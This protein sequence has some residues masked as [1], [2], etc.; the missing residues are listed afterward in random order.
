MPDFSAAIVLLK[1]PIEDLFSSASGTLK[2][3][4]S[5]IR[6]TAKVKNLHKKLYDSQ[7][8]KTIWNTD[9]SLSLTS[10]F[11]PVSIQSNANNGNSGTRLTSLDD[12]PENHSI[13][14]GTVGQGK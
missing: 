13:I 4:I 12:L 5:H 1:K 3:K 9:R 7:R 10:F 14:F 11:Y 8:V 2:T 6:A